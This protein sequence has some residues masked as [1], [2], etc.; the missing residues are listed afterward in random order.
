VKT[1]NSGDYTSET[2]YASV[3]L[4]TVLRSFASNAGNWSEGSYS[5]PN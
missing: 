5:K 3:G 4:F 2:M 1:Y